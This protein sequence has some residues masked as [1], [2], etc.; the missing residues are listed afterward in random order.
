MST[1]EREP[2]NGPEDGPD[3]EIEAVL[4]AP[5]SMVVRSTDPDGVALELLEVLHAELVPTADLRAAIAARTPGAIRGDDAVLCELHELRDLADRIGA[6]R[7][8]VGGA[9]DATRLRAS[10]ATGLAVH[11]DAIRSA[12]TA[13]DDARAELRRAERVLAGSG[14]ADEDSDFDQWWTSDSGSLHEAP[15]AGLDVDTEA[16]PERDDRTP[17]EEAQLAADRQLIRRA[18]ILLVLESLAG[19]AVFLAGGGILGLT[20]PGIALVW[21]ALIIARQRADKVG[22]EEAADNLATV[23]ALTRQA[24]GGEADRLPDESKPSAR[25]EAAVSAARSRV[26]LAEDAWHSLVGPD[27]DPD[28]LDGVLRA[29]DPQYEQ[30]PV[31]VVQRSP[32]VRAAERHLRR[33]EADW[34]VVWWALGRDIPDVTDADRIVDGLRDEG[35]DRVRLQTASAAV[36]TRNAVA[37]AD[38]PIDPVEFASMTALLPEGVRVVLV[39]PADAPEGETV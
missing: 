27:A 22:V 15:R 20:L 25:A 28:D 39:V 21:I 12:K 30:L 31:S 6:A 16:R 2:G 9:I 34:K 24:Y 5:G 14:D 18:I 33:L 36:E 38:A 17:E 32:S 3:D 4:R 26:R 8:M 1:S 35:I 11:P 29:H 23:D 7:S 10:A 37:V 13:L 19:V